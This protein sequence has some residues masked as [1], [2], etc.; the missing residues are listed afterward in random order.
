MICLM[1]QQRAVLQTKNKVWPNAGPREDGLYIKN[2]K[3][4]GHLKQRLF[5]KHQLSC[6][7]FYFFIFIFFIFLFLVN[8]KP[9]SLL[10]PI[11]KR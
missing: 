6:F 4:L 8:T 5:S 1:S 7:L 9:S 11:I 2:T 10:K 3:T